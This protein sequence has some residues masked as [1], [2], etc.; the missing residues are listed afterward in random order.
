[1]T[2]NSFT[3]IISFTNGVKGVIK[4]K[5]DRYG[6]ECVEN[7]FLKLPN[8]Q[9]YEL[10]KRT[11]DGFLAAVEMDDG[12]E[13]LINAC[14]VN[15][16]FPSTVMQMIEKQSRE[17]GMRILVSP[18]ISERTASICEQN[19]MGYF[20]YAGNC[21]FVGHSIYLSEKGNKN[22]RP[23]KYKTAAIFERSSVVSSLILRELFA[24]VV[25]VWKLKYLAEKVNCSIGQV[26]KVMNFLLENAWAEKTKDGYM[27]REPE[28]LLHEWSSTYGK[29]EAAA[30]ACYSLDNVSVLEKKLKLLKKDMGIESYLTGFS[31]GV[32]YAPVIRYN[33]VHLYLAPEDIQEAIA[34]LEIKEVSSGSNIVIFPLENDS[35][36]KDS[37]EIEESLVVSPV[38][39]YL[40]CMQLKGRGEEMAEAV[41]MRE[42]IK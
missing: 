8:V 27:L 16:L 41:L 29:K 35:Y 18:Y 9:K 14:V 19:G 39:I 25:K 32:R 28:V 3:V 23:K 31:G 21:W 36:I 17:Q 42:I 2:H 4:V 37:R 1:M 13:F 33:K 34:Y 38:Q 6:L 22:P 26:S 11:K 30:Y 24:D 12:Y 15:Q 20:D 5:I 10:V 40:D 7:K